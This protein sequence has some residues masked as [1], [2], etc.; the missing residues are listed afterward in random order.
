MSREIYTGINF[1]ARWKSHE[2]HDAQVHHNRTGQL[3]PFRQVTNCNN[4]Y[5]PAIY[6]S[7]FKLPIGIF[8][9]Y[10]WTS[11]QNRVRL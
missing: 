4:M 11:C 7:G 10:E 9:Y 5:L 3:N 6:L 2:V 1:D 8:R